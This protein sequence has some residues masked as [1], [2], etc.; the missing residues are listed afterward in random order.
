MI[1]RTLYFGNPAYL[2]TANEQLVI[3][4]PET[5][6]TKNTPIEDIGL[7]I[8]DNRQI[9]ITQASLAKL[10]ANNSAIIT[11]DDTHHPT[12][13]MLSLDGHTLQSQK[14]KAQ[15]EATVPLKKQLWQQTVMVK[16][17]NQSA[18]LK[19]WRVENKLMLNYAANVKSGDSE[20]NEAKAAAY[21][22]KNIF[23]ESLAFRRERFGPP[24]NNLLNYGY[25]ILRALVARS[26]VA[27][28]LLPTL[29][30]HHR[31]QYNAYCLADDIM[32]PYRPYVDSM[33]CQII[34]NNGKYL[35][36]TPNMKKMLL[37]IPAMDVTIEGQKSPLMN[38]VQRTTASLAKCFEGT[39]RKI[40]YPEMEPDYYP[41]VNKENNIS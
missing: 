19:F 35:E 6:E 23:P 31:N 38:A 13:M 27:S 9:T 14:F 20:N 5:G 21:Y 1:K 17:E 28:G 37:G 40:L 30:I 39:A 26:L 2:K 32:E 33:V 25:A 7:I 3:E 29:G 8:L 24:P 16:I 22:W 15:I 34:R 10:L 41:F 4:F 36:M 18:L 12:G 11:C